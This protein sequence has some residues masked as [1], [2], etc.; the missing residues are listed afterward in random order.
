MMNLRQ[1]ARRQAGAGFAAIL[2]LWGIAWAAW[3]PCMA[4]QASAGN[5]AATLRTLETQR[6]AAQSRHDN[7]E[8]ELILDSDLVWVES[9]KLLT[10]GEY[11]SQLKLSAA[12]PAAAME[13][14]TVKRF[15][16]AAIVIGSYREKHAPG[17]KAS[18]ERWRFEDTWVFKA[19]RWVLVAAAA[20]PE[21]K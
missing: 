14:M 11:L 19:Q 15:G 9:G 13:A 4:Q 20:S 5:E 21:A 3:L 18:A 12:Q 6:F 2:F 16:D 8:L 17:A 1:S 7:R 10:K